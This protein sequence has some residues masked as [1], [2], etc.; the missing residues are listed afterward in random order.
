MTKQ[1]IGPRIPRSWLE[2]LSYENWDV[3]A[4]DEIESG[5]SPSLFVE[6]YSPPSGAGGHFA[7][8][9]REDWLA[10]Y[11][12]AEERGERVLLDWKGEEPPSC[13]HDVRAAAAPLALRLKW[14]TL[15]SKR[16]F[17][18]KHINLLERGCAQYC[19]CGLSLWQVRHLLVQ[20]VHC[21]QNTHSHDTF[22]HGKGHP[23]IAGTDVSLTTR[24]RVAQEPTRLKN[25]ALWCL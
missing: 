19:H 14:T 9:T 17:T 6:K 11:D 1:V 21:R 16:F 12:L 22:V 4:T 18:G 7:S 8:I 24:T 23:H 25:C 15:F 3:V 5:R 10:L 13:V 20:L 2:D